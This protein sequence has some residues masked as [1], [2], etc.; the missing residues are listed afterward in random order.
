MDNNLYYRDFVVAWFNYMIEFDKAERHAGRS[1]GSERCFES[2]MQGYYRNIER[3]KNNYDVG[4]YSLVKRDY[5]FIVSEAIHMPVFLK[6]NFNYFLEKYGVNIYELDKRRV[7]K[8][9]RIIERGSVNT[10]V[11]YRFLYEY[12]D[13][14]FHMGNQQEQIDVIE[15]M[16]CEYEKKST[17]PSK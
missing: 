11:E 4:K 14:L 15:K 2:T 6:E 7:N 10:L 13:D 9:N 17:P 8:I 16:L 5:K 12:V 1:I 3:V